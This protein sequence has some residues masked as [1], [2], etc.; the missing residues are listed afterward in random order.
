MDIVI[1]VVDG[2][3][4]NR[5]CVCSSSVMRSELA[6]VT[7][8]VNQNYA[9]VECFPWPFA[10]IMHHNYAGPPAMMESKIFITSEIMLIW[11]PHNSWWCVFFCFRVRYACIFDPRLQ[12]PCVVCYPPARP[13]H[14]IYSRTRFTQ[15]NWI[16]QRIYAH[17][18]RW[19]R[20][21]WHW[22]RWKR[23]MCECECK[24]GK[25]FEKIKRKK[26]IPKDT[27]RTTGW[28]RKETKN[29]ERQLAGNG[30]G[31]NTMHSQLHSIDSL[32]HWW[33]LPCH[34]SNDHLE[35]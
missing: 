22:M 28:E 7:R 12:S 5:A 3:L 20:W 29:C 32:L 30:M 35:L 1:V 18:L 15:F 31:W 16:T 24:V 2:C 26:K 17:T 11:A 10:C 19:L 4:I 13:F 25:K 33:H 27:E 6:S 21:L 14:H 34:S 8:H 9:L 23:E